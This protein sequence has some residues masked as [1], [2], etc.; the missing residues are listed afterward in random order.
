MSNVDIHV[1]IA[2]LLT[3]SGLWNK[4]LES[5]VS[6]LQGY[7]THFWVVTSYRTI[8]QIDKIITN[9]KIQSLL[10]PVSWIRSWDSSVEVTTERLLKELRA[11]GK[12]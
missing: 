3:H 1:A 2:Q 10:S 4:D 11:L 7:K 6:Y 12:L 5:A 8:V 9:N